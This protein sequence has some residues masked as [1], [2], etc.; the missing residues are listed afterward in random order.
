MW[1]CLIQ[2]ITHAVCVF[3]TAAVRYVL[4]SL[5]IARM[6]NGC[7]LNHELCD[8]GIFIG[9]NANLILKYDGMN[10]WCLCVKISSV[11]SGREWMGLKMPLPQTLF[12]DFICIVCLY[13]NDC[14][15]NAFVVCEIKI[16]YLLT[17]LEQTRPFCIGYPYL[18]RAA[19]FFRYLHVYFHLKFCTL[20]TWSI[21]THPLGPVPDG[22]HL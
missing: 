21:I 9:G 3:E 8:A 14:N 20:V 4:C 1:R 2:T 12:V 16:T 22:Q 19:S 18:Y 13:C 7:R 11:G 10:E 5:R 17:Y 6:I 15:T